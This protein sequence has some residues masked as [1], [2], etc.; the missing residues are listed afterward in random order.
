MALNTSRFVESLLLVE[1]PRTDHTPLKREVP[2]WSTFEDLKA[3]VHPI[4]P[5]ELVAA[6]D[7]NHGRAVARIA[8]LLELDSKIF[9]PATTAWSRC[10]AIAEE[11]AEVV[12]VEGT[13]ASAV[14]ASLQQM[15]S[16][17][18]LLTDTWPGN[19]EIGKWVIEGYSTMFAELDS[20]LAEHRV[21][22]DLALIQVGAGGL[23]AAL[24]MYTKGLVDRGRC[25]VLGVEPRESACLARSLI[26]GKASRAD[27]ALN[28]IAAGL[29]C[30]E[31]SPF[32]WPI[33]KDQLD[34][35]LVIDDSHIVDAIRSLEDDGLA[36]SETGASGVAGL[37]AGAARDFGGLGVLSQKSVLL[38]VTEGVTSVDI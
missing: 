31:P 1:D 26:L 15:T 9:L 14:E 21:K 11:G 37:L 28:S 13:Y 20:Q 25:H 35:V 8:R 27:G 19:V 33:L 18:L 7:G 36:T 10:R 24:L 2:D 5:L 32:A 30:D 4:R 6:S 3:L 34:G 16:W 12:L 29:N 23:A 17:S 38:V 22:P